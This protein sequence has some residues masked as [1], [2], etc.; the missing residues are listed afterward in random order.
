[1]QHPAIWK[2]IEA[3]KKLQNMNKNKIEALSAQGLPA[4]KKNYVDLDTRI[5]YLVEDFEN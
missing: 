3:L 5:K 1:M 2:F 4:K